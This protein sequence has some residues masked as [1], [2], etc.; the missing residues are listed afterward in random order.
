MDLF[1]DVININLVGTFNVISLVAEKM[2]ENEVNAKDERG[3]IINTSSVAAYEG[4]RGQVAYAASKGGLVSLTLPIA[5]DLAYY[6]IRIVT[7]A[8]GLCETPLLGALPEEVKAD[9]ANEVLFPK[10][11][12]D[13]DEF[14]TLAEHII[15]NAYINGET[16]RF[17]GGL[18]MGPG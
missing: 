5:R 9:L 14:A 3:V 16:I 17:D 12:A 8:P 6:G 7:V 11:L 1:K 2:A 15:N 4:Q 10:R 18:R 13:A